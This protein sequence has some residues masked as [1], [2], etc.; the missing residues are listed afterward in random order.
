MTISLTIE[1]PFQKRPG[2]Y[3]SNIV[4]RVWWMW[5]AVKIIHVSEDVYAETA[6]VWEE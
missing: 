4:T 1:G 2:K 6:W 5:F 3:K